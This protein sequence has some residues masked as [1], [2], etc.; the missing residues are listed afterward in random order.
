MPPFDEL[1]A[2]VWGQSLATFAVKSS[3]T[4]ILTRAET[5]LQHWRQDLQPVPPQTTWTIEREGGGLI[6][7]NDQTGE[8]QLI[9]NPNRMV[10][11]LESLASLQIAA[12]HQAATTVHGG[13]VAKGGKGVLIVGPSHSGKSTLTTYLW[14][15]GWDLLADDVS[16]IDDQNLCAIPVLR[17][18]SLRRPSLSLIGEDLFHK[19][20]ETPSCDETPEGWVFHPSELEGRPRPAAT[21][22]S[23][24]IFLKR[25]NTDV[26][27]A[28]L[29]KIL[30]AFAMV[31]L[32]PYTNVIRAVGFGDAMPRLENLLNHVPAYDLGRGELQAMAATVEQLVDTLAQP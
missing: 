2:V 10:S 13:L 11:V 19:I 25:S 21:R 6:I 3:D 20:L 7:H 32:L 17:R 8:N 14:R 1:R 22:I 27:P 18:V 29:E 15:R 16:I 28:R 30:P 26:P 4:E 9:E 31:A 24:I 12:N 23:A 5:V